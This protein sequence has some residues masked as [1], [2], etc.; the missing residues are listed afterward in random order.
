MSH[1]LEAISTYPSSFSWSLSET[2]TSL[3]TSTFLHQLLLGDPEAFPSQI[4]SLRRVLGQTWSQTSGT[5]TEN[6]WW[7]FQLLP[8]AHDQGS[9]L[10]RRWTSKSRD[11]PSSSAPSS[12]HYVRYLNSTQTFTPDP[13]GEIHCLRPENRGLGLGGAGSHLNRFTL[14]FKTPLYVLKDILMNTL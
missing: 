11:L 9:G 2:K 14:N 5:C 1:S 4:I 7:F 8:R 6:L 13:E 10:E 3:S 12:S